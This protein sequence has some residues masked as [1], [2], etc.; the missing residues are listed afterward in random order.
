MMQS[1]TLRELLVAG[2]NSF[3]A[4]MQEACE[5][6][7]CDRHLLG[8]YLTAVENGF[9]ID[10]LFQDDAY[11]LSGGAGNFVLSTSCI[12]KHVYL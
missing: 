5:A 4:Q 1:A 7:G 10:E 3:V 11:R 9:E 6:R 8:L 12:G 2:V